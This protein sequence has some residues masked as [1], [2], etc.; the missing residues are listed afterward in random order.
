MKNN[1]INYVKIGKFFKKIL[2]NIKQLPK[3][4]IKI[5]KILKKIIK[6]YEKKF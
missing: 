1:E 2:K 5:G 3:I 4:Y 6:K